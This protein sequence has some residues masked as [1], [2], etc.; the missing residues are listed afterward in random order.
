M[1]LYLVRHGQTE[2]N[3]NGRA[4]GH[5]DIELDATGKAQAQCL[6]SAFQEIGISRV[7]SSDLARAKQTAQAVHQVTGG[8]F[9]I[10]TRLRERS[11]GT[12]E[13]LQFD[14]VLR[15]REEIEK[16]GVDLF[17]HRPDEG[18][19]M[20]D[21]WDRVTS[22]VTD[23]SAQKEPLAI[24]THGGTLSVLLAQLLRATAA[25]S[26]SF[27]FGNTALTELDRHPEG[28][29][30]LIRFNDTSHLKEMKSIEG[31]LD[32]THR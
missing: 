1:R 15:R 25:T 6:A 4:Q 29:Y 9:I 27:R 11:F 23:L 22:I 16:Q 3:V 5:T 21:V 28:H 2:W 30:T 20:Q 18:E 32:G 24:I 8:E 19:S 26:R 12:W 7:I 14:E 13:G 10:D 17:Q 31:S